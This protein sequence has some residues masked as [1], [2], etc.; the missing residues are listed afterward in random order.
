MLAVK[1]LHILFSHFLLR[2]LAGEVGGLMGLLLGASVLTLAEVL[3]IL[4]VMFTSKL[5]KRK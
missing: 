3:D 4:I 2:L 5:F 1:V